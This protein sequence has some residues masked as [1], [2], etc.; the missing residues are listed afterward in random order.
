MTL[1][2]AVVAAIAPMLIYPIFVYWMDRFEKEPLVLIGAAFLWGLVPAAALSL[3]TQA[4]IGAPFLL[5]DSTGRLADVAVAVAVAPL[6][7]EFFKAIALLMLF[8]IWRDEFDG[9]FDGVIYGS[10]VG[11]G[12]AAIE[13]ILYF[14]DADSSLV[15]SRSVL[16]GLNHALYTSLTGIGFGVAR[17]ARSRPLRFLAPAVG[18]MAAVALHALHNTVLLLSADA[19]GLFWA[20]VLIDWTGILLVFVV[21]LLAVSRER[22]RLVEELRE[23]VARSTLSPAQY[24]VVCSPLRRTRARLEALFLGGPRAYWR[25]GR[26]FQTLTELAFKKHARRRRGDAGA[27]LELI[28]DLRLRAA[29]FS[30][31]HAHLA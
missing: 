19:P 22:T 28:E 21:M 25:A 13:N 18:L 24:A 7:E 31:E 9:V 11:F 1:P 5:L 17:L 10:L 2:G 12:F 4:A 20:A 27:R 23:E 29:A 8:L 15:F 16:F 3:L 26:Y 6:S 30:A 14:L